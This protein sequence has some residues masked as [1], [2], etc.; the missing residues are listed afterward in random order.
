MFLQVKGVAR[1]AEGQRRISLGQVLLA[2]KR[3]LDASARAESTK[4]DA[5]PRGTQAAIPLPNLNLGTVPKLRL[6][7][8]ESLHGV[9]AGGAATGDEPGHDGKGHADEDEDESR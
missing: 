9:A 6:L 3:P 7:A 8:A 1:S 5:A 2:T 4:S